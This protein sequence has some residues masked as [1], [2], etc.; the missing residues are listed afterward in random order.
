[1]SVS[2]GSYLGQTTPLESVG[3]WSFV[4][5][6]PDLADDMV[7][8]L[9]RAIDRGKDVLGSRLP[10]ARETTMANT[11]AFA[12]NPDSIHPGTLRYLREIGLVR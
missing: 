8:R 12:P 7:Y 4:L 6:R 5:A 9:V 10:K 3:S 2:A 1:L 11:S